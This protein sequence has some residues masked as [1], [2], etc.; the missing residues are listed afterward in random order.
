MRA[1]RS[2]WATA[3]NWYARPRSIFRGLRGRDIEEVMADL[4]AWQRSAANDERY[5]W[6]GPH[7]GVV[8]LALASVTNACWD[9]WAKH[10]GVPLWRLLLDLSPEELVARSICRTWKMCSRPPK[11]I[12]MLRDARSHERERESIIRPRLS[13]LRHIR[14]LVQLRRAS[15]LRENCRRSLAAGF[16]RGEAEGGIRV[17]RPRSAAN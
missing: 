10:R 2:R 7:K 17:A 8:H 3:T 16:H 4:G 9:L 13:R 15:N 14:R 12:E 6:L 1:W 5:R 11:P